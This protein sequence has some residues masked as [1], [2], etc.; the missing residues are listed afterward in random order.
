M[1]DFLLLTTEK[2]IRQVKN[3]LEGEIIQ[4]FTHAG[5][6]LFLAGTQEGLFLVEYSEKEELMALKKK[7]DDFPVSKVVDI[8]SDRNGRFIITSQDEGIYR[9]EVNTT[10]VGITLETILENPDGLLDNC[11]ASRLIGK[12]ELWVTTMGGG[13]V[14]FTNDE[15]ND[16]WVN[17][18]TIN[19]GD[20]LVSDNVRCIFEEAGKVMSGFD[21]TAMEWSGSWMIN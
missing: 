6:N 11:Q 19:T 12:N 18:G 17:T 2:N 13:I 3:N 20:G 8:I 10:T 21:C 9:I 1:R 5:G 4:S 16:N 14:R 7:I 15:A